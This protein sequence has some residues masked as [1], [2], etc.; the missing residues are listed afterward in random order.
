[1]KAWVIVLIVGLVG[2]GVFV[3]LKTRKGAEVVGA[4]PSA[5][6]VGGIG[7]QGISRPPITSIFASAA[8]A[9]RSAVSTVG[10]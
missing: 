4:A 8:T 10:R 9:L 2:L 6:T 1:M 3:Y 7:V 5:T